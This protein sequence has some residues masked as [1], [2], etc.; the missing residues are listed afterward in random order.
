MHKSHEDRPSTVFLPDWLKR[1]AGTLALTGAL[2]T[3]CKAPLPEQG[4]PSLAALD[5]ATRAPLPAGIRAVN[6]VTL[7]E[8]AQDSHISIASAERVSSGNKTYLISAG[9]GVEGSSEHPIDCNKSKASLVPKLGLGLVVQLK[10][11]NTTYRSSMATP[12]SKDI[13]V[14]YPKDQAR[15]NSNMPKSKSIPLSST[16]PV[17]G[18][19]VYMVGNA[20]DNNH[21]VVPNMTPAEYVGKFK[22]ID[23]LI[24]P[25]TPNHIRPGDSGGSALESNNTQFGIVIAGIDRP[26]TIKEIN[27]HYD[28]DLTGNPTEHYRAVEVLPIDP[29]MLEALTAGPQTCS[30][31]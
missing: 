26:I 2:L 13:A 22:D 20:P 19:V 15:A 25:D 9:H 18:D 12:S 11:A 24:G 30:L 31:Q 10:A 16:S 14:L 21:N 5:L 8:V 1:T 28:L 6:V 17:I 23:I 3:G 27:T 7:R 29:P 4:P